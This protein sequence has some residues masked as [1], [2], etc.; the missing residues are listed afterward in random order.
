MLKLILRVVA[1]V[2]PRLSWFIRESYYTLNGWRFDDIKRSVTTSQGG[3]NINTLTFAA[4]LDIVRARGAHQPKVAFVSTLPPEDTGIATCSFYSWQGSEHDVDLFCPVSDTDMFFALGRKIQTSH[5]A[6]LDVKTLLTADGIAQYEQI[7]LSIGNSNHHI[8]IFECLQKI[9]SFGS[10]DRVVLHIHDPCLLNLVQ[11]GTTSSNLQLYELMRALYADKL[12]DAVVDG[13]ES[14]KTHAGLAE[15]GVLGNR[16]FYSLGIDKFIANSEAAANLLRQDLDGLPVSVETVFHP[17]F[18][19][20]GFDVAV[21]EEPKENP[22]EIV[23]GSFGVPG[24]SKLTH[25]ITDA[26]ERLHQKGWKVRLV[27]AGFSAKRYAE[28]MQNQARGLNISI[29]DG[30][31]DVQLATAMA[32]VDVAVQLRA[33]NLGESSGVVPQLLAMNKRVIVSALGSF[34]EYGDAV[35]FAPQGVTAEALALLIEEQF[36]SP[37]GADHAQRYVQDHSPHKFREAFFAA[38]ARLAEAR[39]PAI[40]RNKTAKSLVSSP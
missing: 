16:Y 1:R 10:L 18:L 19:P 7:V 40:L 13:S 30:P 9:A 17:V 3:S 26:V 14:W 31:T 22:Q 39:G 12:A 35:T 33:K 23:V 6:V 28:A 15:L 25:V 37:S 29:F 4:S 5:V 8:Y 20:S 24:P 2:S 11:Q 27:I 32:T 36:R 34:L 21:A 38:L